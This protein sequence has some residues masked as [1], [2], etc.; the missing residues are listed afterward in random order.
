MFLAIHGWCPTEVGLT[1]LPQGS[2]SLITERIV[3]HENSLYDG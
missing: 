1:R 3:K 2:L